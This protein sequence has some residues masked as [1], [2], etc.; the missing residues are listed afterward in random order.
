MV[1]K[2]KSDKDL[3][4]T[5][6]VT[7]GPGQPDK[8]G[9]SG[10]QTENKFKLKRLHPQAVHGNCRSPHLT[11][12]HNPTDMY[13]HERQCEPSAVHSAMEA[14]PPGSPSISTGSQDIIM[15][16]NYNSSKFIY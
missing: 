2:K 7:M 14:M 4:F 9:R 16:S 13:S 3:V 1:S 11:S 12:E 6:P 8:T 10:G 5:D 15:D